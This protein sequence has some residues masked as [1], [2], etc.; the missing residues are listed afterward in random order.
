M[1]LPLLFDRA[2]VGTVMTSFHKEHNDDDTHKVIR[3][4]G[5]IYERGRTVAAMGET[6]A[7]PFVP[8]QF[9][10]SGTMTFVPTIANTAIVYH[11][12][13]MRMF[14]EFQI[15][16]AVVAGVASNRLRLQIPNGYWAARST[17]NIIRVIDSGAAAAA[18]FAIVS[19]FASSGVPPAGRVVEFAL[20]GNGNWAAGGAANTSIQGELS[21]E[22]RTG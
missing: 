6:I 4:S 13:G 17:L 7:V 2:F 21:F 12:I 11:L 14:L 9:T 1:K 18:G 8:A 20:I 15:I 10:A 19:D 16:N 3:A 5:A 22:V